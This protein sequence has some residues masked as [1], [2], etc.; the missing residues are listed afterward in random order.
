[1]KIAAEAKEGVNPGVNPKKTNDLEVVSVSMNSRKSLIALSLQIESHHQ[2]CIP[3]QSS[4]DV[5]AD[6]FG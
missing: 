4:Y 3:V 2:Y 1:M 6:D 5:I